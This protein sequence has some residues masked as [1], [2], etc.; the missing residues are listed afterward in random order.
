MTLDNY[1]IV[2]SYSDTRAIPN[3]MNLDLVVQMEEG[4]R[5]SRLVP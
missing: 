3:D 1:I 2:T 5:E 4:E